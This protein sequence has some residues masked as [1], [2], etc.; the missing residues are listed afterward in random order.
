MD[1]SAADG[2]AH[3]HLDG[4]LEAEVLVAFADAL[5]FLWAVTTSE[6]GDKGSRPGQ[7]V[8]RKKAWRPKFGSLAQEVIVT[9][10]AT[11]PN[12]TPEVSG[13]ALGT[14]YSLALEPMWCRLHHTN[15]E[16]SPWP[17]SRVMTPSSCRP[18]SPD[19]R[20]SNMRYGS[21]WSLLFSVPAAAVTIYFPGP[22]GF[23]F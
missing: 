23:C 9:G 14:M 6:C 3:S 17:T 19:P 18:S 21:A 2:H 1:S 8:K 15:H 20:P 22:R 7:D 4:G 12:S 16:R 10:T 11:H 5:A 13:D